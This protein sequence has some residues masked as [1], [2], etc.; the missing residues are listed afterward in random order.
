[1]IPLLVARAG[2]LGFL[3]LL[4]ACRPSPERQV[5]RACG[6]PQTRAAGN[7][8][9]LSGT[10]SEVHPFPTQWEAGTGLR[11]KARSRD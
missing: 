9:I 5:D 8:F 3:I 6:E 1:M 2:W 4:L 11:G 7:T 10:L